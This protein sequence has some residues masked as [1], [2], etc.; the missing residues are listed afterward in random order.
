MINAMKRDVQECKQWISKDKRTS[1]GDRDPKQANLISSQ[2]KSQSPPKKSEGRLGPEITEIRGKS[3]ESKGSNEISHRETNSYKRK[4][5]NN[6]NM[7][8]Q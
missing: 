6:L 1:S 4:N 8:Q 3:L 5:K 2:S 7:P